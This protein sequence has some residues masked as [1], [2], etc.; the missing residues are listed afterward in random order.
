MAEKKVLRNNEPQDIEDRHDAKY[1]NDVPLSS[2]LRNGKA[3]T[4]PSFDKD[5]AWRK[6]KGY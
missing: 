2:W 3:D 4:K 5:N 1:D 6:G